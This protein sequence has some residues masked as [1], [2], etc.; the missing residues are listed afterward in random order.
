MKRAITAFTLAGALTL[1]LSMLPLH[2]ASA[3][4]RIGISIG[5]GP[6]PLPVYFQ[7][8]CPG[9]GYYWVP[10]YWAWGPYGYFWVP[11]AWVW[12][13]VVGFVWTPGFWGWRGGYWWWHPGYWGRHV[14]FYGGIAYGHGYNGH[15]YHGGYWRNGRFHY[16]RAVTNLAPS[17]LHGH[18]SYNRPVKRPAGKGKRVSY[19]GG[20]GG[21][22]LEPTTRQRREARAH[23]IAPTHMQM[24]NLADARQN[25]AMRLTNNHGHPV[26][27]TYGP[28]DPTRAARDPRLTSLA[29]GHNEPAGQS[30]PDDP[31]AKPIGTLG[32][33][34]TKPNPPAVRIAP[35][36]VL[37]AKPRPIK[38]QPIHLPNQNPSP[39]TPQPRPNLPPARP[40]T[41]VP[42]LNM[43]T[44]PI[45][46]IHT[47]PVATPR[48]QPVTPIIRPHPRPPQSNL[49]EPHHHRQPRP[50]PIHP[51]HRPP[52]QPIRPPTQHPPHM[53]PR[54]RSR[55][56]P[57]SH[58]RRSGSGQHHR[59]R[60]G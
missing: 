15:G 56:A 28:H 1:S 48:P 46:P 21:I 41:S 55:I 7:P 50:V 11:G 20:K 14:G 5:F 22:N 53:A 52:P 17:L 13:P 9:Y 57:P 36:P 18:Y 42:T 47:H 29:P 45:H 39:I 26:K 59:G 43:P 19:N 16:N 58:H 8:R 54:H 4:V 37:V 12:P 49:G 31:G 40:P 32:P 25:P 51:V 3:G 24:L 6:P 34:P 27:A 33:Q 44:R 30:V 35:P 10:G 2:S 23:H 38:P 60:T